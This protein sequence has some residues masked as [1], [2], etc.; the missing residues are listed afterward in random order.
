MFHD[1]H[2]WWNE[3]L[4]SQQQPFKLL[5]LVMYWNP[6]KRVSHRLEICAL[7]E[8]SLLQDQIQLGMGSNV[9]L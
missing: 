2:C 7:K 5:K 1:L 8:R 4:Y 3:E 6:C 9:Q